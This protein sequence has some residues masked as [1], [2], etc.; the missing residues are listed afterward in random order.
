MFLYF[1]LFDILN[2]LEDIPFEN[3]FSLSHNSRHISLINEP[4]KKLRTSN[5][6]FGLFKQKL[7]KSRPTRYDL[8]NN[9][10]I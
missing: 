7:L 6:T 2:I 5:E 10:I 8:F 9:L 4:L 3:G 1:V